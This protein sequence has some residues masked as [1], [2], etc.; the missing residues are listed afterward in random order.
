MQREI[1]KA[2]A[3]AKLPTSPA[4]A[5]RIVQLSKDPDAGIRDF[6]ELLSADPA[7]A[8]RLLQA[9]NAAETGQRQRVTTL[10]RAVTLLGTRRVKSLALGFQLVAHLDRLGG[11]KFDMPRFWQHALVRGCLARALAEAYVPAHADEAFLV[12]LLQDCGIIV[13]VQ[14]LGAEYAE[15]VQDGGRTP[16]ALLEAEAAEF[17]HTHVDAVGALMAAWKLPTEIA[18]PIERHHLAPDPDELNDDFAKLHAVSYVVGTTSLDS[19]LEG[20]DADRSLAE[21]AARLFDF[22]EAQWQAIQEKAATEYAASAAIYGDKLAQ[23]VDVLDILGEANRQLSRVADETE[24]RVADLM[25]A[26]ERMLGN[27]QRVAKSLREYRERAAIDPLTG[28]L[29]RGALAR[30]LRTLVADRSRE[31]C[32]F[33]VVFLDLDDFKSINDVYG[34]VVGDQVLKAAAGILHAVVG[35]RGIVGRFG[36]EEFVAVVPH[37][38]AEA[39]CAL[40]NQIVERMRASEPATLGIANRLTV[41]AGAVWCDLVSVQS[42]ED[43]IAHADVLMY[44]AKRAG[45]DRC[46][47]ESRSGGQRTESAGTAG[48][49]GKESAAPRR[50][51]RDE[52]VP[53]DE[54]AELVAVASRLSDAELSKPVG[55]RKE[56]RDHVFVPCRVEVLAYLDDDLCFEPGVIRDFSTGGAGLVLARPLV[57]GE[58]LQL[59]FGEGG[60]QHALLAMVAFCRTIENH[61]HHI[62]V[63]F[64]PRDGRSAQEASV[65]VKDLGVADTAVPAP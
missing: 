58:A 28:L 8:A 40:S 39:V 34:H 14:V 2:F 13:L 23:D 22:D 21:T 33:G 16:S 3:D 35:D 38:S 64:I 62:G 60:A 6:A 19:A 27:H 20:T 47:F 52:K 32:Q 7:L 50:Y 63:Q 31:I 36:G 9:A 51:V 57:R 10:E 17:P 1:E 41:S 48:C 18:D 4:L 11:A 46:V 15:L 56:G 30:Q 37:A 44:R 42:V 43:M 5:L 49:A 24:Q 53:H 55:L 12:G 65:A 59:F 45:K 54:L 29:N 26:Q 61:F 25:V